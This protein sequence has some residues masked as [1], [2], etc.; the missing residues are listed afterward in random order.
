MNNER[1]SIDNE[2]KTVNS[3]CHQANKRLKEDYIVWVET[4]GKKSSKM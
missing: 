4:Q 1:T 2:Y 3:E